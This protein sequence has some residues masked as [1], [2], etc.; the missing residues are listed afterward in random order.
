MPATENT[1]LKPSIDDVLALAI[2]EFGTGHGRRLELY[3]QAKAFYDRT[4]EVFR[5]P[6]SDRSFKTIRPGT[7]RRL[8]DKAALHLTTD[9]PI[10]TALPRDKTS[11]RA[12][13]DADMQEEW[14]LAF[15]HQVSRSASMPPFFAMGK[16][17]FFGAGIIKGPIYD[18]EAWGTKPKQSEY[19]TQELYDEAKAEYESRKAEKFPY[20]V[21]NIHP[22][23]VAWDH[24]NPLDPE[25]VI[26]RYTMSMS[27]ASV[28]F[29]H[30]ENIQKA[31][32][33]GTIEIIEYWSKYWH[34]KI[35][36]GEPLTFAWGPPEEEGDKPK[37]ERGVVKNIYGFNPF[38]IVYG[39]WGMG[40]PKVEDSAV[41]MLFG[42]ADELIEEAVVQSVL[43]WN[44]VSYGYQKILSHDP[45]TTR[46]EM[47]ELSAVMQAS[48]DGN[49]PRPMEQPDAPAWLEQRLNELQNSIVAN[50]YATS[51][52]GQR[53]VGTTSG[54]QEG[55]LIGEGR[56]MFSPINDGQAQAASRIVQRAAWIHENLVDEPMSMM[57]MPVDGRTQM[58][59]I[60]PN[61]WRGQ[62][63][64]TV[65]FEPVDPTRDDRRA[66]LGLNLWSQGAIDWWEMQE[67]YLRN[68]DASGTLQKRM[69]EVALQNP[70]IQEIFTQVAIEEWG[71]DDEMQRMQ[72]SAGEAVGMGGPTAVGDFPIAGGN[73]DPTSPGQPGTPPPAGGP[74]ELAASAPRRGQPTDLPTRQGRSSPAGAYGQINDA[75]SG[76][77]G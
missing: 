60:K 76:F 66:M 13:E 47:G 10:V 71:I 52:G 74:E 50:T 57:A 48:P 31:A 9:N 4:F 15:L 42:A 6:P 68:P 44:T 45:D 22:E 2:H 72:E 51:L 37:V 12:Q 61:I 5:T 1:M 41:P 39:V 32:T 14:A 27:A 75:D 24:Q 69:L 33:T 73:M 59:T 23:T 64:L 65:E 25:W 63:N 62:Y 30:F 3:R 70:K 26:Q 29:P 43:N 18:F 40:G 54:H 55:L 21:E 58:L 36:D 20:V 46:E 53:Q 8:V 16:E 49:L 35:S 19:D 67:K 11:A 28:K 7:A 56:L 77:R 38:Q 17:V 34:V